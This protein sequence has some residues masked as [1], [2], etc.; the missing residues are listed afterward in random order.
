MC[1]VSENDVILSAFK[2]ENGE[3]ETQ[4]QTERFQIHAFNC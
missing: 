2:Y 1:A 4:H 3:A